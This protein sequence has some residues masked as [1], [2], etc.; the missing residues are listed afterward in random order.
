M[1]PEEGWPGVLY[2]TWRLSRVTVDTEAAAYQ[3][4]WEKEIAS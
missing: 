1:C 2:S 3:Y 4:D